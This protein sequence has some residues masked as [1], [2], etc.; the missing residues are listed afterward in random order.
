MID[1]I[2]SMK[3]FLDNTVGSLTLIQRAVLIGSLLGDGSLRKQG[4]R[5]NALLEVNHA[6]KHSQYVDWKYKIFQTHVLTP[7]KRRFG[8]G[9]RVVYR[10]TTRSLPV[11][12]VY[13]NWFYD[14]KEKRIPR[15]LILDPL[16]LTVWFMDD[17]NKS[18]T[19]YYLNTQ[20][21]QYEDQKYLIDLLEKSFGIHST[22]NR[23]KK[24]YR[25]R[26]AVSGISNFNKLIS[27][28]IVSCLK[29][30][31]SDDPVTTD[32]KGKALI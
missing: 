10:F 6:A 28:Y 17:G 9:K 3:S 13:Y 4:T 30:K 31:L 23:D 18:R 19:S 26:I 8:N 25:I 20:Q 22:L 21:F 7:P 27:P 16:S 1:Y 15:D 5:T 12:T 24:Y 32:P 2:N 11:F 29:Y 14:R